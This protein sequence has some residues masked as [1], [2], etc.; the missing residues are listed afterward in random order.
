MRALFMPSVTAELIRKTAS[1]TDPPGAA[2]ASPNHGRRVLAIG[3]GSS[4]TPLGGPLST[5][6][7]SGLG[8][9]FGGLFAMLAPYVVDVTAVSVQSIGPLGSANPLHRRRYPRAFAGRQDRGWSCLWPVGA[10]HQINRTV[11]RGQPATGREEGLLIVR[12]GLL[13]QLLET[14][15]TL[16][17]YAIY[18]F[19]G[20]ALRGTD[21][22]EQPLVRPLR[23]MM[24]A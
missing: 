24:S 18:H 20:G 19:D 9:G 22:L 12:V 8:M 17:R 10:H 3:L 6:A 21:A 13:E 14:Y 15:I 1:R 11:G 5:L 4:L 16:T 23:R 7:A 2:R